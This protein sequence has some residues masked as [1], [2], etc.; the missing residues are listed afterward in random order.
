VVLARKGVLLV[1]FVLT[2]L[3]LVS[4]MA[5]VNASK[6]TNDFY[7][8]AYITTVTIDWQHS[9]GNKHVLF[10]VTEEGIVKDILNVEVGT[11]TLDVVAEVLDT[12]AVTG[13]VTAK[14]VIDFSGGVIE[15]TLTG[16]LPYADISYG[17]LEWDGIFV[18]HGDM[19]VKGEN[20]VINEGTPQLPVYATVFD[21]YSW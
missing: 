4:P 1:L 6:T 20:Y 18:G 3:F 11:F 10:H 19:R 15:G 12:E 2:T 7:L 8:K 9:A 21:G 5:M 16:K 17:K 14:Y 13:I